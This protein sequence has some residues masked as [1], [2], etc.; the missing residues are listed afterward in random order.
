[1]AAP[2]NYLTGRPTLELLLAQAGLEAPTVGPGQALPVFGEFLAL[3]QDPGAAEAG[4]GAEVIRDGHGGELLALHLA[5]R[6]PVPDPLLDP[7]REPVGR[8]I[9]IRWIYPVPRR[10][11]FTAQELWL[12]DFA[13]PAAFARAVAGTAEWIF[14]DAAGT[15]DCEVFSDD[16]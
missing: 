13:E 5:I 12:R 11:Q 1:M 14:A 15:L 8:T 3:P 16:D 7:T 6:Y 10:R 9:G 2:L 4:F